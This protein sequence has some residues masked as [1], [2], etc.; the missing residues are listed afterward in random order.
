MLF[1][2]KSVLECIRL[3]RFRLGRFC[4]GLRGYDGASV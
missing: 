1:L 3:G 4:L 2:V